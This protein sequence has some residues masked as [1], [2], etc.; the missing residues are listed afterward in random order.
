SRHVAGEQVVPRECTR[1]RPLSRAGHVGGK[2]FRYLSWVVLCALLAVVGKRRFGR[3]GQ[4]TGRAERPYGAEH[5]GCFKGTPCCPGRAHLC[6]LPQE[7][8]QVQLRSCS[9]SVG[10]TACSNSSRASAIAHRAVH[11]GRS[12]TVNRALGGALGRGP[13]G[14]CLL[15]DVR[16]VHCALWP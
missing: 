13:C 1:R 16:N 4:D 12:A 8:W 7:R 2:A 9:S 5:E 11:A 6:P 14:G 10:R 3:R 15:L